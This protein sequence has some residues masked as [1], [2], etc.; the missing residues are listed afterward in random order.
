MY[1]EKA[2]IFYNF[3]LFLVSDNKNIKRSLND[4]LV[5]QTHVLYCM[6]I[7]CDAVFNVEAA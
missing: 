2:D 7:F 5:W 4:D 1:T 6:F 3:F